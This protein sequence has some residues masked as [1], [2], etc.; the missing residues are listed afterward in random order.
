MDKIIQ[1]SQERD[2]HYVN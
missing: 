1:K 2:K